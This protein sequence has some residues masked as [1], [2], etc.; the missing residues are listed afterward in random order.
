MFKNGH[1]FSFTME[2]SSFSQGKGLI[3]GLKGNAGTLGE[4][5]GWGQR[6]DGNKGT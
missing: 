3:M 2:V 6:I 4:M 5:N 1:L